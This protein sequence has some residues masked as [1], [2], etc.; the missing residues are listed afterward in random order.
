MDLGLEPVQASP[1]AS[2]ATFGL[3]L[4][5][6]YKPQGPGGYHREGNQRFDGYV[7]A[8]DSAEQVG[9]DARHAQ[10][11]AAQ[12]HLRVGHA[13]GLHEGRVVVGAEPG[14]GAYKGTRQGQN[15]QEKQILF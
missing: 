8:D 2:S 15:N 14:Q 12:P 13:E 10:G 3:S 7:V 11:G 1:T 5:H 4:I 6:I 9:R